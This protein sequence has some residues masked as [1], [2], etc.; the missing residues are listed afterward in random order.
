LEKTRHNPYL[1]LFNKLSLAFG[2]VTGFLSLGIFFIATAAIAVS[3]YVLLVS[4]P[5]EYSYGQDDI[6]LADLIALA[7]LALATWR[8][9]R[10][11]RESQTPLWPLLKRLA[12]ILTFVTL[13]LL[14]A[15]GIMASILF[16]EP[17][18]ANE[19]LAGGA[20]DLMLYGVFSIFIIAIYGATPLPP[21]SFKRI[22]KETRYPGDK[23]PRTQATVQSQSHQLLIPQ[24]KITCKD[25]M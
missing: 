12:F 10:R 18:L 5:F 16:V 1:Q 14:S 25:A 9:F 7:L 4:A 19:Q 21:L 17:D 22:R 23:K 6:A 11:G 15:L 3:S 20:D 24:L 8:Y 13:L 2:H